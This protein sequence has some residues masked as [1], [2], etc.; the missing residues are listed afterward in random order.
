METLDVAG[1][2]RA[3][4]AR[5][6]RPQHALQERLGISRTSMHRRMTG[7]SQFD[8][9]ELV[10]IAEFLGVEVGEIFRRAAVVNPAQASA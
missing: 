8:A 5:Q 3:E 2:V 10:I 7:Q 6:R 1:N 4:L 9:R